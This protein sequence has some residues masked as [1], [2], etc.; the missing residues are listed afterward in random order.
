MC[1]VVCVPVCV[2]ARAGAR[3]RTHRKVAELPAASPVP[4]LELE[5]EEAPHRVECVEVT[6]FEGEQ[7]ISYILR[8][9]EG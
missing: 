8:V 7:H 1:G 6:L 2:C 3:A 4:E 9:V 5:E